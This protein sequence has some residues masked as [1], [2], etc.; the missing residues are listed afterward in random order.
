MSQ[1]YP[2]VYIQVNYKQSARM[3]QWWKGVKLVSEGPRMSIFLFINTNV[4]C[5]DAG[6][7]IYIFSHNKAIKHI[8]YY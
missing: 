8:A 6:T 1:E 4:F 3:G 5:S 2:R 7:V